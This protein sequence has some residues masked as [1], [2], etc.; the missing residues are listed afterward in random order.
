MLDIVAPDFKSHTAERTA[1]IDAQRKR[2]VC[3]R[4][5][6]G[7]RNEMGAVSERTLDGK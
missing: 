6:S 4:A 5:L 3:R 2:W 7:K 1:V